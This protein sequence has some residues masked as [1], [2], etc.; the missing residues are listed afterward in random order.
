MTG[1]ILK[2][3]LGALVVMFIVATLVFFM[4]RLVPRIVIGMVIVMVV[5]SFGK[6]PLCVSGRIYCGNLLLLVIRI[7]RLFW[8]M[9]C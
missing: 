2:R 1:Y 5:R 7:I 8:A 3:T 6:M 9:M 4:L